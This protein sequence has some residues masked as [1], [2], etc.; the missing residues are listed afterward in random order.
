MHVAPVFYTYKLNNERA[1]NNILHRG[2]IEWNTLDA[3]VCHLDFKEFKWLQTKSLK[4]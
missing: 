1:R 3:N 2:A 4:L